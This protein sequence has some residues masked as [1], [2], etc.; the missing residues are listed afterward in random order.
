MS[1]TTTATLLLLSSMPALSQSSSTPLSFEVADVKVN[2]SGSQEMFANLQNGRVSVRNAPLKLLITAAWNIPPSALEGGPGWLEIDRF[3]VVAKAAATA[4]EADLRLMLRALLMERFKLT[5]HQDQKSMAAYV[6]TV[7]K[8]GSKLQPSEAAKPGEERC[9][10]GEGTPGDV[11]VA[12][13][14]MTMDDLAQSLPQMAGGYFRG[15]PV[16]DQT[17][18]K[19]SYDFKLDWTPAARYNATTHGDTPAGSGETGTV[20][21][22]FEAV[23]AQLGLNLESKKV[24]V[25]IIVIDHVERAPTEN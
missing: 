17:D 20:L 16:V 13:H 25:P 24:P 12:C 10:P 7:G 2:K 19:G 18:L 15:T 11:H 1:R 3:D 9:G 22:V 5:V 6:M 23:E 14:H 21:S 4:S 8:R